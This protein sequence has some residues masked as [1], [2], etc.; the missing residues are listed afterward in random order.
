MQRMV[1]P[2]SRAARRETKCWTQVPN[3]EC[4]CSLQFLGGSFCGVPSQET[5]GLL[6]SLSHVTRAAF[7]PISLVDT[8]R[9]CFQSQKGAFKTGLCS[10]STAAQPPLWGPRELTPSNRVGMGCQAP[11]ITGPTAVPVSLI[12]R[13]WLRCSAAPRAWGRGFL[14][15]LGV[16]VRVQV[17]PH[18]RCPFFLSQSGSQRDG[19]FSRLMVDLGLE[20]QASRSESMFLHPSLHSTDQGGKT[21][22]T[23]GPLRLPFP[24]RRAEGTALAESRASKP[25]TRLMQEQTGPG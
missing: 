10:T 15:H 16:P 2:G 25:H 20:P 5:A 7:I 24:W 12:G 4:D 11:G 18:I 9:G 17:T 13:D 8:E 23:T 3:T 14:D 19:C 6:L 1:F 21:A 22:K